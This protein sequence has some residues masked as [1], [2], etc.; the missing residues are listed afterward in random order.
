MIYTTRTTSALALCAAACL[1]VL[2]A[3]G[4]GEDGKASSKEPTS[5]ASGTDEAGEG[6]VGGIPEVVAEVNGEEVTRDEFALIYDAQLEQATAAAAQGGEQPDEAAL[7][8]QTVNNLVDTELLAQEAEARGIEVS[9][10][11]VDAELASL[12]ESNQMGSAQE[13]IDAVEAQGTTEEQVRSQVELQVMVEQLVADEVGPSEP[14]EEELRAI[15]AQAKQ[16]AAASGQGQQIPPFA[17]VRDQIVEQAQTD[18][19]GT[20]AK[21]LVEELRKDADITINL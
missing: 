4:G 8:E 1:L 20:V 12:A 9:D 16:Q 13:F 5:Q 3:C 6:A 17:E 7:K 10:E 11:D 15:Y 19:V 14:T 21:D 18:Q 2:T